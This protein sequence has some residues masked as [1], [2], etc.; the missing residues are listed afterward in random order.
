MTETFSLEWNDFHSNLLNSMRNL[1]HGE[2]LQDV[3]LVGDDQQ[4]LRANKLVLSFS[5]DYFN[6]VF[7]NNGQSNVVLCLQGL[8]K[9]DL[10]NCLDYMYYGEVQILQQ[11]LERFL[12]KIPNK[13]V[14][15]YPRNWQ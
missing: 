2:H 5:S 14:D 7:M 12:N 9:Q 1:R 11:D 4:Q 6:T 8:T 3:T 13:R 15:Q 10:Q